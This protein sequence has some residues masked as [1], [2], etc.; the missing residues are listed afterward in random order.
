MQNFIHN[1]L[2]FR[3]FSFFEYLEFKEDQTETIDEII[4]ILYPYQMNPEIKNLTTATYS[5]SP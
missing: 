5:T 1:E 4:E 2:G 3:D